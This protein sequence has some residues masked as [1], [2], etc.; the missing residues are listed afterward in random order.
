MS[1]T[2]IT[3]ETLTDLDNHTTCECGNKTI[4]EYVWTDPNGDSESCPLCMVAW[5]GMQIDAMKELIYQQSMLSPEN[6]AI[7]INQKYAEIMGTDM[8][9]LMYHELDFSKVK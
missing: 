7:V 5:M 1:D 2:T 8:E 4:Y 3:V 6:T 9:Y